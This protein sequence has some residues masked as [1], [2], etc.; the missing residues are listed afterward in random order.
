MN[1]QIILLNM[2]TMMKLYDGFSFFSSELILLRPVAEPTGLKDFL[3]K[4][5]DSLHKQLQIIHQSNRKWG[6]SMD[7]KYF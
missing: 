6:P 3:L 2:I 1:K 5:T 7:C 4:S